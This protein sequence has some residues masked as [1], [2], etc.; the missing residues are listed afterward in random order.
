[1]EAA[2]RVAVVVGSSRPTR[3][4][5]GI[6]AW[7]Q[8]ALQ[9]SRSSAVVRSVRYELLDLAEVN[10]PFLDEPLIPAL[11][12]YQHAHTKAWSQTVSGYDGFI[13]VFP[14]YNWG[15]PAI[16]KNTL[17]FLFNEWADKPVS[18]ATY[19]TRGGNRAAKQL[20]SVLA[21]L[22][23]RE[24]HD[25]LEI[26]ITINDVDSQWQVKDLDAVLGPHR[27]QLGHIAGQMA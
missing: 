23:M 22:H 2:K 25:H 11:G 26:V 20:Q 17:D 14:Q 4:C 3:I 24:L 9:E 21:G 7:I 12:E 16:L 27:D 15:Y 13:F 1:M 8:Q 10:L 5:P 18:F 19:G 6:A